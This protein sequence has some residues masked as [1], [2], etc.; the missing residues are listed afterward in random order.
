MTWQSIEWNAVAP[1][2]WRNGAGQTRELVAW[3]TAQDWMWRISVA[4]IAQ[5]GPFSSYPG[6]ARWFAVLSGA[7]VR[8]TMNGA[9][10]ILELNA[11]SAPVDFD[12]DWP[13]V[14]ELV[15]GPTRDFNVM[16]RKDAA[17]AKLKRIHGHFQ[18]TITQEIF[19][20]ICSNE[21]VVLISEPKSANPALLALPPKSF[22]WQKLSAG[23]EV[24]I[25]GE[26]ALY[27]EVELCP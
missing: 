8:L 18:T 27:L 20:G 19:V 3:P 16:V 2:P 11:A 12:G 5:N 4:D 1:T 15:N 6:V 25:E 24:R 10:Q 21:S 22:T 7:G 13:V 14:C 26:D 23:S 17:G 9:A